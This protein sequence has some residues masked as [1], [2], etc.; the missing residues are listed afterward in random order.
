MHPFERILFVSKSD[1][2]AGP[3]AA[4]ILQKKLLLD[5]YVVESRGL[6]VLFPEPVNAKAEAG[7][8]SHGLTKKDHMS[9]PLT[10]DDLD[11]RTLVFALSD[12]TRQKLEEEFHDGESDLVFSLTEYI[13]ENQKQL[14]SP[15]GGSLADYARCYDELDEM[16]TAAYQKIRKEAIKN[17]STGL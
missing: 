3:M 6:V 17:D 5:E 8:V 9:E 16:L 12:A 11:E 15:Y 13:G 14:F 2:A 1:T 10:L 4:A 7:L